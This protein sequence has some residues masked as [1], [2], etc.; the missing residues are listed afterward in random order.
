MGSS[1]LTLLVALART[2]VFAVDRRVYQIRLKDTL[3]ADK[4]ANETDQVA[5][6]L[7]FID[8]E[9]ARTHLSLRNIVSSDDVIFLPLSPIFFSPTLC[10]SATLPLSLSISAL[11]SLSVSVSISFSLPFSVSFSLFFLCLF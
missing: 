11:L 2:L 7:L 3:N 6:R 5:I 4:F 1:P 10:F 9:Y 8:V